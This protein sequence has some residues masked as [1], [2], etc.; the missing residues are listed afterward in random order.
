MSDDIREVLAIVYDT[1]M[2]IDRTAVKVT[3]HN[4]R[5]VRANTTVFD[6]SL[7]YS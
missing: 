1:E 2:P 5:C 4:R 3:R 6:F 7:P